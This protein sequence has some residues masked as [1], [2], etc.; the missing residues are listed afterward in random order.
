M[1]LD[2]DSFSKVYEVYIAMILDVGCQ[3]APHLSPS[4]KKLVDVRSIHRKHFHSHFHH[5]I[6][7]LAATIGS[8]DVD[9][10]YI[11][12]LLLCYELCYVKVLC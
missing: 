6:Q 10:L 11:I 1:P 12:Y 2:F 9:I 8:N 3:P 7:D 4:F 5:T